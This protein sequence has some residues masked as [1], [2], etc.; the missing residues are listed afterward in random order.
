MELVAV[1]GTKPKFLFFYAFYRNLK[2]KD[3]I[4]RNISRIKR[5]FL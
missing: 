2:D 1:V 3:H 5:I 4:K